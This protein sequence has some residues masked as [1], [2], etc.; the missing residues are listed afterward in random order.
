MAILDRQKKSRPNRLGR[1]L[2]NVPLRARRATHARPRHDADVF[3]GNDL[4]VDQA[5]AEI[6]FPGGRQEGTVYDC[7]AAVL[8]SATTGERDICSCA[9]DVIEDILGLHAAR[10]TDLRARAA[11][12]QSKFSGHIDDELGAHR[13]GEIDLCAAQNDVSNANDVNT[14]VTRDGIESLAV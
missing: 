11:A 10:G 4:S 14:R 9:D 5:W 6:D 1:E 13:A 7:S 3:A 12:R 2:P 8:A